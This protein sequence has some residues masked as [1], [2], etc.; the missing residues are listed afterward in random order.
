MH[1]DKHYKNVVVDNGSS[2]KKGFS[3][4]DMN[5]FLRVV[6]PML[7]DDTKITNDIPF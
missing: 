1:S 3:V 7:K 2:I 6:R 5:G 4:A